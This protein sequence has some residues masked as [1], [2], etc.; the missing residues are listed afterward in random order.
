MH[1]FAGAKRKLGKKEAELL[2]PLEEGRNFQKEQEP[3][4]SN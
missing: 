3:S 4:R 1:L 2:F